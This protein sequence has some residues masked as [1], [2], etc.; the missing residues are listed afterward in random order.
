MVKSVLLTFEMNAR[1]TTPHFFQADGGTFGEIKMKIL[2]T[3]TTYFILLLFVSPLLSAQD[4]YKYRTFSL[5]ASLATVLKQTDQKLA[6]VKVT[7]S[8]P[9]LMQEFT[10]WPPSISGA[11]YRPDTVEQMRFSFYDG[12]LYKISV[13]YDRSSTEGLTAEDLV[14]SVAAKYGAAK[15]VALAIDS[16]TE[17]NQRTVAWWEDSQYSLNLAQSSFTGAFELV[18]CSKRVND[19]A[20]L[21]LANAL[22]LDNQEAPQREADRKKKNMDELEVTRQKNQNS[23]K[24]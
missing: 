22:K 6:D 17:E 4:L 9:G 13:V 11:P 24:P 5:G 21:V 14:K 7:H 16:P 15:Y 1:D 23:F 8:R 20:E 2:F 19:E 3:S 10:W 12:E 18:I